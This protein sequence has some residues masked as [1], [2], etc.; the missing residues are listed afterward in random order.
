MYKYLDK[1]VK[2]DET[3]EMEEDEED[4]IDVDEGDYAT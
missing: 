2:K 4:D 3:A 1:S